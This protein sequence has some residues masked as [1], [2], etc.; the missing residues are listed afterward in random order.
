MAK[1]KSEQIKIYVA[2]GLAVVLLI[3]AYF[4]FV[5]EKENPHKGYSPTTASFAEVEV[6]E[7]RPINPHEFRL[8]E[9]VAYDYSQTVIRDI[10]SSLKAPKK[11]E[12][13]DEEEEKAKPNLIQAVT[14]KLTGILVGGSKPVAI[15][16]GE[17]I[18]DGDWIGDY[19]VSRI[20]NKDVLLVSNN[21]S[22][23]LEM[24][25]NE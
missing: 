16:D 25:K 4:R 13:P 7:V 12:S 1:E 5:R 14:L 15:I 11:L 19:R 6:P 21:E 9:P 23:T 2:I 17:F 20:G 22:I 24:V 3:T 8:R 18:H 10:F